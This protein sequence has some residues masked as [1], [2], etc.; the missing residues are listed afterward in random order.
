MTQATKQ[1]FIFT[2]N[3]QEHETET[4]LTIS[5][6]LSEESSEEIARAKLQALNPELVIGQLVDAFQE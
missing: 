6:P 2:A 3:S 4:E 1:T 5:I